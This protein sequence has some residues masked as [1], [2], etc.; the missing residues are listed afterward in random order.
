[1]RVSTRK[2]V[3]GDRLL[4]EFLLAWE[5]GDKKRGTARTVP[6]KR[7]PWRFLGETSR[8]LMN[9]SGQPR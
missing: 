8:V 2:V 7:R 6:Q 1:M 3:T 9:L 4:G 5:T